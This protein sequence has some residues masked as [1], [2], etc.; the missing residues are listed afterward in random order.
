[1]EPSGRSGAKWP[2]APASSQSDRD[3]G[4]PVCWIAGT[5]AATRGSSGEYLALEDG[6]C[7]SDS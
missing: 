1:V 7:N 5:I 4:A 6:G 2:L 3:V